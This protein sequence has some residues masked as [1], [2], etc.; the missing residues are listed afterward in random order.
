MFCGW[1]CCV[2]RLL[3]ACPT[4]VLIDSMKASL[5]D[6]GCI[7]PLLP[8]VHDKVRQRMPKDETKLA[9]LFLVV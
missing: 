8:T 5:F 4:A 1:L 9:S 2:F 6:D 3:S 7:K